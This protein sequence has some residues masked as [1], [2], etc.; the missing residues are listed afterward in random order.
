M[1]SG[2][3]EEKLLWFV[4]LNSLLDILNLH[5]FLNKLKE[6]W[7][8]EVIYFGN[9]GV[10]NMCLDKCLKSSVSEQSSTVNSA[11]GPKHYLNMYDRTFII[12][13]HHSGGNWVGKYLCQ[14]DMWN[15]RTV[16][17]P[18]SCWWQV[19]ICNSENLLQPVQMQIF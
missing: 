7:P 10:W 5:N 3:E 8:S 13:F 19:F 14:W 6:K 15:L 16:S 11:N 1:T 4:S 2:I 18:I 9:D 17:S 12:Y